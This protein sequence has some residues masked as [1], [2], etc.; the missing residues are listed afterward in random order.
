MATVLVTNADRMMTQA[1]SRKDGIELKFADGAEGLIPFTDIP[2]IGDASA[3][4]SIELPNPY[5]IELKNRAGDVAEVPWDFAR[6]YC[7]PGYRPRVEALAAVG[8][9]SLG[10]RIR[11]ARQS[12]GVTQQE[13]ASSAGIGRVTLVRIEKGEQSP[14]YETLAALVKALGRPFGGLVA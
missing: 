14:R 11:D 8:R 6:H 5:M 3:L 10:Q 2:E 12:A 7:D 13:L 9:A 1:R 4:A